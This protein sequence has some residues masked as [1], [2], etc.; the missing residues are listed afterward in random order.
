MSQKINLRALTEDELTR[1]VERL[2]EKSYRS[3]QIQ[4]WMYKKLAM[5]FDE[6]T[7]LSKS[8]R[9]ELNRKAYLSNLE[10]VRR[11]KSRDGT[12]K[13]LFRLEDG[14]T[15]ESV[16]IPAGSR[17]TL[18][19]S[20]QVGCAMGCR[21][22]QTGAF[23]LKRNMTSYEITDQVIS[24]MRLLMGT[25]KRSSVTRAKMVTN[26]VLMGMG[27]PL[28]NVNEVLCALW[29]INGAIGIPKKSITLSTAG[30]I[31]G[32]RLLAKEAPDINLAVSL[33]ASSDRV[34]SMIMPINRRYSMK[35]LLQE[36]KEYPLS[37]RR[38][39]TFEYVLIAGVNDSGSD[40]RR[41][42]KLLHGIP[43]KINLI[44]LNNIRRTR[45][46]VLQ[47]PP[48]S[49]E[50]RPTRYQAP[51]EMVIETFRKTLHDAGMTVMVR[52]SKGADIAA[53]CGQLKSKEAP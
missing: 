20:T 44:P 18:C 14:E 6:M 22:C 53:A 8:F 23:G 40:A 1:F 50:L 13:F 4:S 46:G 42:V 16:L 29:V 11:Q 5:S 15:I 17:L 38:R 2:G 48:L 9:T 49:C 12:E 45:P 43:A 7:S 19:I 51:S 24:I 33:N 31:P 27:E 26:I 47:E 32:I 21:F 36:C 34:R 41:L 37:R 10:L 28:D 35:K 3:R 30:I 39:I 52:K 25:V